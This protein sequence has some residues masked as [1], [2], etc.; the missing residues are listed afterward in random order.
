MHADCAH[1]N[2]IG[3]LCTYIHEVFSDCQVFAVRGRGAMGVVV[4][5]PDEKSIAS[6]R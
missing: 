5:G 4:K 1:D 6:F 3:R 2:S